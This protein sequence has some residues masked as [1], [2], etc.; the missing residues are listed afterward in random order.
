MDASSSPTTACTRALTAADPWVRIIT[1]VIARSLTALQRGA[2]ADLRMS[3]EEV[4]R[5]PAVDLLAPSPALCPGSAGWHHGR[6]DLGVDPVFYD[7]A[8]VLDSLR[9]VDTM[10]LAGAVLRAIATEA[11][12][13]W[14]VRGLHFS[15][16]LQ[17]HLAARLRERIEAYLS[18][19][20][21]PALLTPCW[22]VPISRMSVTVITARDLA[23]DALMCVRSTDEFAAVEAAYG[24]DR[25]RR[26]G[27]FCR[28]L[29]L[30]LL[31]VAIG[32]LTVQI[33][34]QRAA[35]MRACRRLG[36]PRSSPASP[37]TPS[38]TG[39]GG[40]WVPSGYALPRRHS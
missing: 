27:P 9:M 23:L 39:G 26:T 17:A 14:N 4:V 24:T 7:P 32:F 36:W 37:P 15:H 33:Y 10:V 40:G 21:N 22:G 8:A 5:A 25:R 13:Q 19:R 2:A 11:A 12:V 29:I 34:L 6:A 31:L 38:F 20:P 1:T 18:H 3:P 35:V 16:Y 28:P 30:M